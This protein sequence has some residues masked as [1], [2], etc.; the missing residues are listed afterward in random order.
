MKKHI[1]IMMACMI[2]IAGC[3]ANEY[4]TPET[5]AS[6]EDT[7]VTETENNTIMLQYRN[8]YN[9]LCTVMAES[10]E[11]VDEYST[12]LGAL[13]PFETGQLEYDF[14]D[15]EYIIALDTKLSYLG[16]DAYT[17]AGINSVCWLMK[18]EKPEET[19]VYYA[20][21]AESQEGHLL[22]KLVNDIEIESFRFPEGKIALDQSGSADTVITVN[23][24]L[25]E[26]FEGLYG[27]ILNADDRTGIKELEYGYDVIGD[28]VVRIYGKTFTYMSEK[29]KKVL[30]VEL[31]DQLT[32][33]IRFFEIDEDSSYVSRLET[34]IDDLKQDTD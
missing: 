3:S 33:N 10:K 34:L 14:N 32:D 18:L 24:V 8:G 19:T 5:A 29:D 11:T 2:V 25:A 23:T 16:S 7:A 15:A 4:E 28:G 21:D 9:A 30:Y 20:V 13:L 17:P 27:D 26:Q 1:L 22:E 31:I 6:A 12:Y